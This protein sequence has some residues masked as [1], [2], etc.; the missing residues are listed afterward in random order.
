L[1]IDCLPLEIDQQADYEDLLVRH[2][3]GRI[4]Q[5]REDEAKGGCC[6]RAKTPHKA[7]GEVV[8]LTLVRD[9]K[10]RLGIVKE[11]AVLMKQKA[12]EHFKNNSRKVANLEDRIEALETQLEKRMQSEEQLPVI[13]AYAI[14]HKVQAIVLLIA[15]VFPIV[16]PMPRFYLPSL[17]LFD[18]CS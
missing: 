11:R 5:V 3:E 8:E 7:Y 12:V 18:C 1:E 13:R 16:S 9:Y 17:Q 4:A 2:L 10:K 6:K 14:K 15:C